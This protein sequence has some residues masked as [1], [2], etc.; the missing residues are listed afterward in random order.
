V[1]NTNSFNTFYLYSGPTSLLLGMGASLV[2]AICVSILVNENIIIRDVVH[3]P[4]AGGIVVGSASFFIS[5]PVYAI[6]AGF[7][8]GA[9]QSLIQNCI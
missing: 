9:V 5:N 1:E 8:A 6:V 2:S 3:A 7:T 4:I